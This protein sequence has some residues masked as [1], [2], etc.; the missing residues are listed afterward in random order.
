MTMAAIAPQNCMANAAK[1]K[2]EQ[3]KTMMLVA[4]IIGL[5]ALFRYILM[6]PSRALSRCVL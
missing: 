5:A 3:R 6:T 4:I 1:E 2:G